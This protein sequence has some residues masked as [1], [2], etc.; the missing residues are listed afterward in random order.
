MTLK[1]GSTLRLPSICLPLLCGTFLLS[2]A[3]Q[4]EA[5]TLYGAT[6]AGGPGELYTLNPLTGSI[7]Q[8]VGPLHDASNV[9]YPVT[10]LAFNP[11]N[12]L[13]YGSTGNSVPGTA[14]KLITINPLTAQVT[15]I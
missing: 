10:G 1:I 2:L 8:D 6:S 13:L 11:V 5:A 12:G 4:T 14:A 9:N 15:V 7:F 3:G